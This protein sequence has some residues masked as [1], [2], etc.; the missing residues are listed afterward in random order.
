MER[1]AKEA[2]RQRRLRELEEKRFAWSG[3]PGPDPS[4]GFGRSSS[5][6]DVDM[7]TKE[8]LL[9][10]FQ[11][12][13]S[14]Q[15][16]LGRS[17]SARRHRHTVTSVA[18]REL[19][20]YFQLFAASNAPDCS[21]F[22]SLPRS[23]R[24]VQRRTTPWISGQDDN[25]E[26][27]CDRRETDAV[28]PLVRFSSQDPYDK[29][30]NAYSSVS[31]GSARP[32]S[33][34][35]HL[36]SPAMTGHMSVSVE[37]HTLVRGPQPFDLRGPNNNNHTRVANRGEAVVT[38]LDEESPSPPK[39]LDTVPVKNVDPPAQTGSSLEREAE[40][41]DT[42]TVSSTTCDTPLPLDT[43]SSSKKPLFYIL[44]STE[45]DCSVALD[46]SEA[47]SSSL[48]NEGQRLRP[49]DPHQPS[50]SPNDESVSSAKSPE[51]ASAAPSATTEEWDTESCDTTEGRQAAEE[52]AQ[53]GGRKAAHAKG[54]SKSGGG[55]GARTLT[56]TESQGMRK[57]VP[58]GKFTRTGSSKR[59]E[60]PLVRDGGDSRRTL[61][62]Q[63]TPARGRT[64]KTS[65]PPRHSSLP[66][67]ESKA[68]RGSGPSSVGSRM[69]RDAT[70]KKPSG[71]PLRNIPKAPPE[72]KMCRS[73]MRALAQAHVQG[74]ASSENGSSHAPSARNLSE[75]PSFAR[76][77]VA[78][79]SRF[80]KELGAP[81]VPSTP[82]R[83]PS[84]AGRQQKQN[85][86][87]PAGDEQPQ[88]TNLR[89]AQ[90]V[91]AAGRSGSGRRSET[92][93]PPAAREDVRKTG[94]FSDKSSGRS[95]KPSW[96]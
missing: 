48:P 71:K 96:K 28:S 62:D 18:E 16:P 4:G 14:P 55:R 75:V 70:P 95:A 17:A 31:E 22:N 6:S 2:A 74:A 11:R 19:Q 65:R 37:K 29:N 15:S 54:R 41:E 9:D 12:S 45:T 86:L 30:N 26:L 32:R 72:E 76:N 33:V 64:E 67:D 91:R 89:R 61:R 87:L 57:V 63:S 52:D 84:L 50:A 73:A 27:G 56:S 81:S 78:S 43:P 90:S 69:A 77:T 1:E 82:S 46:H 66:P 79:S 49:S 35:V 88:G 58:I 3:G 94:S 40:E 23:G 60:R 21:R 59:A 93:P 83:S 47:E 38:D 42:S 24:P 44:D 39:T 36:P 85:R 20:G 10:F 80:K 25:R 34:R 8:G 5:E 13:Q 51:A 53:R 68:P 7:L 92:P